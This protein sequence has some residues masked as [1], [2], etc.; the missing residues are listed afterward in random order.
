MLVDKD[1][2]VE[3]NQLDGLNECEL[4]AKA[5]KSLV[6]MT[7]QLQQG[8]AEPRV[9][10]AK[11]LHN[12]MVVYELNKLETTCWVKGKRPPSWP[13]LAEQQSSKR[14]TSP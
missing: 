6:H 2:E 12:G 1:P 10:R 9:V 14:G 4:V 13:A 8:P 3:S 5:K 7:A 11:R